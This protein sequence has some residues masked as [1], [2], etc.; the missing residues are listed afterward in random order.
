M[1]STSAM[2]QLIDLTTSQFGWHVL[3]VHAEGNRP[4]ALDIETT[5]EAN[6]WTNPP[7]FVSIALTFDGHT[8][9]VAGP[10]Q[11]PMLKT[12]IETNE[13]VMQNG[14]FDRLML[15]YFW[16]VDAPLKHD[17]MAMQYLLDPDEEKSLE[18]LS[19]RY[20]QLPGYKGVDYHNILDEPWEKVAKMNGEDACRTLQLFRPL[21]D[22]INQDKQLSRVYQWLILPA[23]NTLID[24]T[25]NGVP[26]DKPKLEKLTEQ[27]RV[28]VD[29]LKASL[30]ELTPPPQPDI[31]G[32]EAWPQPSSWRV[33]DKWDPET[34]ELLIRGMGRYKDTHPQGVFNPGSSQQVGH[35]IFDQW[36]LPILE[37]TKKDGKVTDKPSTNKDV[38]LLLE[39]YHCETPEQEEWLSSLRN[40][41]KAAK[42]LSATLD[43]WPKLWDKAGWLHPKYKPLHVV[44]GRLSSSEPNIQQVPRDKRFR[45]CLG[46][47]P[48]HTWMKA[49]Y[50]QIELRIAAWIAQEP[51]MLDAYEAG[52]DLH[53]LT[54]RRVLGIDDVY[55]EV[56]PGTTGRDTGK[57]LNFGLLYGARPK[58]LMKIARQNY[59]M[60]LTEEQATNY[61]DAFFMSY[62]DLSVWHDEVRGRLERDGMI[63]SPLGRVRYLPMA[64]IPWKVA[65]E[66]DIMGKKVGAILE[67]TNHPVQSFA[68]DLTL[69]ALNRVSTQLAG[70]PVRL[71]LE[72]HDE[73]DALAPNHMVQETAEMMKTT[74]EDVSWLHRFG[75]DLGVPVVADIEIGT[76]WGDVHEMEMT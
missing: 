24:L 20:L 46:G 50:S 23:L 70:S 33:T 47:V 76:H 36:E 55:Q 69:M 56:M 18:A 53:A 28:E 21:A 44:T 75:I 6:P 52:E 40:Y 43:A 48:G 73:M 2:E 17:T 42:A 26:V 10:A 19:D 59:N 65:R 8:A 29:R 31:Y 35:I 41:R 66:Q 4:G 12:V 3:K 58:T 72:V 25:I 39:T 13:W 15:K 30:V 51:T 5:V 38:L 68:H 57:T 60:F 54:A 64:K 7:Q 32:K 71:M 45:Q 74:M 37:Y 49:D 1:S 9:F 22:K 63:R 16:D 62:P 67:G 61:W 27:Y 34:G 14:L 11:L